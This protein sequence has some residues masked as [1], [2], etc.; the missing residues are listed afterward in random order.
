V[1]RSRKR[2]DIEGLRAI[3]V[4]FVLL[5]HAGVTQL[6]GGF[7]GVDV[8]FVVSGFLMTSIL[9]REMNSNGRHRI[10]ILGF[11]AR[12][13]RRLIPASTLTL[14]ATAFAA[15]LIL[16]ITRWWEI[17][18]D[19]LASGFYVV[20]WR[21][22]DRSVDY[23]AQDNAPSP[24]QHFWSLSIEEQYYLV[25]PLVVF[26]V[27]WLIYR[28]FGGSPRIWILSVL[29]A[30]F[31]ASLTWSILETSSDPGRAYFVTTTRVWELALGG[32]V[33]VSVVYFD[34]TPKY[35]AAGFAWVGVAVIIGT[36]FVLT[37]DVP[38]PGSVALI[39]TVATAA[40]IA[41]GPAAGN[42]GPGRPS[43]FGRPNAE[44]DKGLPYRQPI[45]LIGGLSYSLYLWHWPFIVI[46][47]YFITD[48]LRDITVLE[49]LLLVAV[50]VIPAWLSYR[51]VESPF[52]HKR[53]FKD[54][55][56]RSLMIALFGLLIVAYSGGFLMSDPDARPNDGTASSIPYVAP[57]EEVQ[58]YGAMVL[59]DSPRT[60]PAG[61]VV[62]NVERILPNPTQGAND[63]PPV[64]DDGCHRD[65]TQTDALPCTYG[66]A[67]SGFTV[68]LVGDSHAAH[69]VNAL[70]YV[71]A[72]RDWK[73]QSYTKSACPFL[74]GTVRG[75]QGQPYTS[76]VKWNENV[77]ALL[78]GPNKPDLVVLS[79]SDYTVLSGGSMGEAMAPAWRALTDAG[80][81]VIVLTDT[82]SSKLVVP[83]C[84][85][86]HRDS[87]QDCVTSRGEALTKQGQSQRE[88]AA[89]APG[90]E[91]VDLNDWICPGDQCPAVIGETLVYRDKT[92]MTA[93]YSR[94]LGPQLDK[95]IG[96]R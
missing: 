95:M 25:W 70:Q 1:K 60:S 93:T 48:G 73:L 63:N 74:V 43:G 83:E 36:G 31:A 6:P 79:N 5:W 10:S 41:F 76:C 9:H 30:V 33:A 90:V 15:W 68:A 37:T 13:A 91:L 77:R 16:P 82:P 17:G 66:N 4:V 49:G 44:G 59:G 92:H 22:A 75:D 38:F 72:E 42:A 57:G 28:V 89:L 23:L 87:L 94:S 50:S 85:A 11:Y 20:N 26:A 39:P 32:L 46:G 12:R 27:G 8:F 81:P 35:L 65:Q 54:S 47:G 29:A 24:V 86:A 55:T 53:Y 2:E 52:Q 71:A 84:V 80:V 56:S 64:Y 14:A 62:S 18:T 45:Q 61:K 3:A 69:W 88:A 58:A 51:F 78:T 19:I 40:V 67:A 96:A 7:V 21:L 34:R